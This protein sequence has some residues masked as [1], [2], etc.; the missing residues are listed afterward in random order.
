MLRSGYVQPPVDGGRVSGSVNTTE[1]ELF[2]ALLVYTA[3]QRVAR[4]A[5]DVFQPGSRASERVREGI[6]VASQ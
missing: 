3:G 4:I 1:I 5:N 2:V 6:D